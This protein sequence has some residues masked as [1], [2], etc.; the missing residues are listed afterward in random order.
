MADGRADGADGAFDVAGAHRALRTLTSEHAAVDARTGEV[1][2]APFGLSAVPGLLRVIPVRLRSPPMTTPR[3]RTASVGG[4]GAIVTGNLKD[5]P[6]G[7]TSGASS[8]STGKEGRFTS[9][10][11]TAVRRRNHELRQHL[12]FS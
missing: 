2:G 12:R 1:Q 7:M 10:S 3:A 5:F 4:A 8:R 9:S 11:G 6:I